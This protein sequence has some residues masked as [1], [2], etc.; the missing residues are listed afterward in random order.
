MKQILVGVN[1]YGVIGKRIAARSQ[2]TLTQALSVPV[3]MRFFF[4]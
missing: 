2:K 1:G 4:F 3:I